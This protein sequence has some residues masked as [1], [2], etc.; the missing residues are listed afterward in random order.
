MPGFAD[1]NGVAVGP[2]GRADPQSQ[3]FRSSALGVENGPFISQVGCFGVSGVGVSYGPSS[4]P[5]LPHLTA[6]LICRSVL[7]SLNGR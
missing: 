5:L 4:I 7:L 6:I 1:M 3:L 2:D